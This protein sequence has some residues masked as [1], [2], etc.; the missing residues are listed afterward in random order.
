MHVVDLI[1]ID[2]IQCD[3]AINSKKKVLEKISQ[4]FTDDVSSLDSSEIFKCLV[5]REKLGST[6]IGHG[7]AIPHARMKSNHNKALG[8]FIRLK[9]SIEFDAIDNK[10][11][12]LLFALLVPSL[13]NDEHLEILSNLAK[14][15]SDEEL[16]RQLRQAKECEDTY[17]IIRR[18]EEKKIH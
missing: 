16:C 7:V 13:S 11:V 17:S 4:I 14:M 10:P 15:F 12:N 2:R 18:W 1:S 6:G 3:L 5:G 9:N 8:V